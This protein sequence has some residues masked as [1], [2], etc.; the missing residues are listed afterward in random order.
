MQKSR[1][2][3]VVKPILP[4]NVHYRSNQHSAL[5]NLLGITKIQLKTPTYKT[6]ST[7]NFHVFN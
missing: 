7:F 3:L 6:L 5:E 4:I 1:F 2:R